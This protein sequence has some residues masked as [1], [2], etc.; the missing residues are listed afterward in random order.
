MNYIYIYSVQTGPGAHPAFCQMGT[1]T[2][3]GVK[4]GRGVLLMTTH[5][6]LVPRS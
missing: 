5:T 6:F 3:L 4:C 2:F 1:G